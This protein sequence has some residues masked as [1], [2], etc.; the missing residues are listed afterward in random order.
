MVSLLGFQLN[1]TRV[2]ASK[3]STVLWCITTT[4]PGAWSVIETLTTCPRESSVGN[5]ASWRARPFVARPTVKRLTPYWR[6]SRWSVPARRA[7]W[8]SVWRTPSV[9]SMTRTPQ[10]CASPP[11]ISGTRPW[12]QEVRTL[13]FSYTLNF[14]WV[15]LPR[16]NSLSLH[17][18][19]KN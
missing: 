17:L 12:C 9:T 18:N 2:L 15:S 16:Y 5:S 14:T 11:K 3:Q 13:F 19:M 8:V 1:W 4:T 10:S 6:E 7:L